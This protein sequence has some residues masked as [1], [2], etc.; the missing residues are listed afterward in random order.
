[1]LHLSQPKWV[2]FV[3][4][5]PLFPRLSKGP[6]CD[7]NRLGV[8]DTAALLADYGRTFPALSV[9][10]YRC[11]VTRSGY[12]QRSDT[13]SIDFIARFCTARFRFCQTTESL[14][15]LPV[16]DS[17]VAT[18]YSLWFRQEPLNVLVVLYTI[19][20]AFSQKFI[21]ELSQH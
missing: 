6:K 21:S 14:I 17:C 7:K 3:T 11:R 1:M 19:L 16:C 5:S 20:F 18:R 4:P 15:L 12:S 8:T 10:A 9:S 13:V 2:V